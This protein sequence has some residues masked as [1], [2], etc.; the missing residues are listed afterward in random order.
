MGVSLTAAR[1]PPC[2]N[3]PPAST[4]PLSTPQDLC[5]SAGPDRCMPCPTPP[6]F[7]RGRTP[8]R[9]PGSSAPADCRSRMIEL[10]LITLTSLLL[11]TLTLSLS[12]LTSS[13]MVL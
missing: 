6:R 3:N 9:E 2:N 4:S 1:V 5:C 11:I 8:T 13:L 7:K 10:I 12:N